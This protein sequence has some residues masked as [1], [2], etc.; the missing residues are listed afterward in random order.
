MTKFNTTNSNLFSNNNK[1]N[2][3][4]WMSELSEIESKEKK[5][6]D[7][8]FDKRGVFAEKTTVYREELNA[9]P[10]YL[11]KYNKNKMIVDA[12][13]MLSK[14]LIGKKYNVGD[15]SVV[16]DNISLSVEISDVPAQFNFPF[17]VSGTKLQKTSTF[18]VNDVEYPFSSAGFGEC[19]SD[20]KSGTL[21]KTAISICTNS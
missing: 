19:L 1:Q 11:D 21:K 6:L 2:V 9:E 12:K 17:Q 13:I 3:P 8:D 10:R 14:F 16:G 4:D 20:L 15:L 18:Y 5:P 7:I